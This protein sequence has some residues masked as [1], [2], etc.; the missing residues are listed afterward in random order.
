[1]TVKVKIF[2][3]SD[4]G[5]QSTICR[6]ACYFETTDLINAS[7]SGGPTCH[8]PPHERDADFALAHLFCQVGL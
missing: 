4:D 5:D 6:I 1:M 8:Q 7:D 3:D 2:L